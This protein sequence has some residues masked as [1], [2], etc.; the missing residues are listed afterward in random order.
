MC[1]VGKNTTLELQR[2][3][4]RRIFSVFSQYLSHY[5]L[6]NQWYFLLQYFLMTKAVH[7]VCSK[8]K[9]PRPPIQTQFLLSKAF[10]QEK[11]NKSGNLYLTSTLPVWKFGK[12]HAQICKTRMYNASF[13]ATWCAVQIVV[14]LF[15]CSRPLTFISRSSNSV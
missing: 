2:E 1:P 14:N 15:S 6:D 13:P 10:Q 8:Y 9:S 11:I 3:T 5:F 7:S 12:W 4:C